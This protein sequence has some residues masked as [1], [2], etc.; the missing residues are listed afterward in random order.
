MVKSRLMFILQL[1][2]LIL[3]LIFNHRGHTGLSNPISLNFPV[4]VF[5]VREDSLYRWFYF[6]PGKIPRVHTAVIS[7]F[8][9][10]D[11]AGDAAGVRPRS[12]LGEVR[13]RTLGPLSWAEQLFKIEVFWFFSDILVHADNVRRDPWRNWGGSQSILLLGERGEVW[14]ELVYFQLIPSKKSLEF[15]NARG[16]W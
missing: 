9:V 5:H 2:F 1:F 10:R 13:L 3:L 6:F 14:C 7:V 12:P 15:E 11:E 4:F 16:G 8:L